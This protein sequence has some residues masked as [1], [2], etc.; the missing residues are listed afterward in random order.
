MLI[1]RGMF[2]QEEAVYW[3]ELKTGEHKP[4]CRECFD[5]YERLAYDLGIESLKCEIIEEKPITLE[6]VR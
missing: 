6:A 4:V 1:T 5:A 3:V 2:C